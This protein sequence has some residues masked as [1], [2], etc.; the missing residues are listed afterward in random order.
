MN[1]TFNIRRFGLNIYK[2]LLEKYR[3][4]LGFW[5]VIALVYLLF[6]GMT[7]LFG[8]N[9]GEYSRGTFAITL[10]QFYCCLVPFLL[11]KNENRH[12]EGIFYGIAPA[13][14]L[15]KTL[16]VF[17][18]LTLL[19]P[20]LT[21][22][23]MLSLDSLLSVMPTEHGFTGHIWSTVFSSDRF[24]SG[25]I[26]HQ[27]SAE[28]Q[29]LIDRM[30]EGIPGI[31]LN[32]FLAMLLGQSTF[33]FFAM[34]FRTHKI[35]KTL[36]VICGAGFIL[37]MGATI[38]IVALANS[39]ESEILNNID[40]DIFITWMENFVKTVMVFTCYILPIIFWVLTYFRI[41]RIQY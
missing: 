27:P 32:P 31:L 9:V 13:S 24:M 6:W 19:F 12:V 33:V 5:A 34:F 25:W 16:T 22:V 10:L 15:E 39:L 4:I 36:L 40:Q 26:S 37:T 3:I 23:L 20:A 18:I 11:Y 35:G 1:A 2:E 28:G 14:T 41:R 38:S 30:F 8:S 29:M 21:T 7:L 17:V